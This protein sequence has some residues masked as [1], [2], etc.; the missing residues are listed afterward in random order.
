[1]KTGTR[2]LGALLPIVVLAAVIAGC[3]DAM[4]PVAPSDGKI[5]LTAQPSAITL[6]PNGE[7]PPTDDTG[8]LVGTADLLAFVSDKSGR[9]VEGVAVLYSSSGGT[10]ETQ[11]P[12]PVFTD[13][14]GFAPNVLTVRENDP[15]DKNG[16][17]TVTAQSG[18]A[19]GTLAVAKVVVPCTP[20]VVVVPGDVSLVG[21][22]CALCSDDVRCLAT[23]TGGVAEDTTGALVAFQWDC[24]NGDLLPDPGQTATCCYDPPTGA[25]AV[26]YNAKL[27]VTINRFPPPKRG[28]TAV[29]DAEVTVTVR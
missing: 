26:N 17:I 11:I 21:D 3:E 6:D 22:T 13:P 23:F 25:T 4:D 24:G 1:M 9:G 28:C 2:F 15:V 27:T 10:L 16:D 20:P 29:G 7:F 12:N 14:N 19:T 8:Q 5:G 18:V